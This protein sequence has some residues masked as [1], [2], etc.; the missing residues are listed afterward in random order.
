MANEMAAMPAKSREI[1][2]HTTTIVVPNTS[3]WI[4]THSEQSNNRM[5]LMMVHADPGTFIELMSPP[6]P[7]ALNPRNI[8]QKPR[9]IGRVAAES[10]TFQTRIAPSTISIMPPAN[11]QRKFLLA[12]EE[13]KRDWFSG[14]SR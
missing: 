3:G 11:I 12:G 10:A 7:M 14:G 8:S 2:T 9:K 1:P 13:L 4:K 5:P 6:R